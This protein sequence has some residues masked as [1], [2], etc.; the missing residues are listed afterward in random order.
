VVGI[1][2]VVMFSKWLSRKKEGKTLNVKE[3]LREME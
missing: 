1:C 2:L 3:K